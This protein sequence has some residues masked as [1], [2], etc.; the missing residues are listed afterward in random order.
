MDMRDL[1]LRVAE[2]YDAGAGTEGHVPG[3]QLLRSVQKRKDLTLPD[4]YIA[5]AR[6]GQGTAAATPWI[7]VFDPRITEDP[8]QG[9]YLAYIFS[10]DLRTVTLTLQQGSTNLE[11]K[12]GRGIALR[13]HLARRAAGIR[14]QMPGD[15]LQGWQRQPD[16][17][18][19]GARAQAYEKGSIV[20][21]AY[22]VASLPPEVKIQADLLRATRLLQDAAA[23]EKVW[24]ID[25]GK[26]TTQVGYEGVGHAVE[27]PLGGFHPKN[28]S[29]YLANIPARQQVKNRDHER[30]IAQFGPYVLE[31]GYKP[32]TDLVHPRDLVLRERVPRSMD[33]GAPEWLVEVKVIRAGNPTSAV[34]EVMGQLHEYSYFLYGEKS[35][36]R[37]HL[38]GLFTEDIGVYSHYLEGHGIASIWKASGGWSGSALAAEWNM[39]G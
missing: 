26:S 35:L 24:M 28:S 17:R 13:Q 15:S 27:D 10:A 23:A 19:R 32:I 9:L 16:F 6:G 31:R 12:L 25:E 30:L 36:P 29:E 33:S 22:Q 39:V 1:L 18:D 14:Q 34:R 5:K 21:R 37:P 3:Q 20:A 11:R 8:K 38:I 2:L 4:G 7:G